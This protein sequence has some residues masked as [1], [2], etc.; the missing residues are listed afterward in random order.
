MDVM[1]EAKY[2]AKSQRDAARRDRILD[3]AKYKLGMNMDDIQSQIAERRERV[4]REK[5]IEMEEAETHR[6]LT[7]M[8]DAAARQAVLDKKAALKATLDFRSLNQQPQMS[9]T[10]DMNNPDALKMSGS[11]RVQ[12]DQCGVSALQS[13]DGEDL[14]AADRKRR[15]KQ[16]CLQWT[17]EAAMEH[18]KVATERRDQA[19]MEIRALETQVQMTARLEGENANAAKS[20]RQQMIQ[21]NIEMAAEQRKSRR[22]QK[23]KEDEVNKRDI[24]NSLD[25]LLK[26]DPALGFGPDGRILTDR[27]RG[28][29]KDQVDEVRKSQREQ[30][31]E[32]QTRR[33]YA[34]QDR[35]EYGAV[36]KK[37]A[38]Q[39]YLMEREAERQKKE[40][41]QQAI[42]ENLEMTKT[43]K[44]TTVH[45]NEISPAFFGQFQTSCR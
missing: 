1:D 32:E 41:N 22:L 45:Q 26:E 4:A 8:A 36:L 24:S 12:A 10:W 15:Q 2:R 44:T 37:Q 35:E 7:R 27:Y 29:S 11:M 20:A 3:P 31:A 40:R 30:A 13:F 14:G 6:E 42:T 9:D 33:Q 16:Q 21:T 18:E 34:N 17:M 19:T 25:G 23:Q 38:R 5:Q 43:K 28:F 39:I